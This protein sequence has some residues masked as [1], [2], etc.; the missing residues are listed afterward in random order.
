[1]TALPTPEQWVLKKLTVEQ[2]AEEIER[3]IDFVDRDG[4][5]VQLPTKFVRHF[6]NRDDGALPTIVAVS[7]LPLVF[8]D[9]GVWAEDRLDQLRG[10]DFRIQ[11]EV[12][13][14]VPKPGSVTADG[15]IEA[16]TFLTEKWLV[17]V[18]TDY[19]GK[20]TI[21]AAALT[22]IER[23]LL[24]QRP[25]FFVTAGRRG[26]GK[27]T[28]LV[29]L[30]K[31]VTGIWPAAAAWST[32]EE[33]RRKALLSYFLHGVAYILWDNIA[34]G[35]QITCPH[36]EKSCTAAYY[37]DRKLGVSQIVATAASTIHFFTGNNI[38]PRGDLASRSLEVRLELDRYDPE[39][40]DFKHPDPIGWTDNMRAEILGAFYTILLGNPT[41]KKPRNAPMRTRFKIWW[42][43]VGSALEHAAMLANPDREVDFR[44]MFLSREDEDEDSTSLAEVL[45]ILSRRWP[46]TF[47]ANDIALLVNDQSDPQGRAVRE[48]LYPGAP[49]NHM[50]TPKSVAGRLKSHC[51]EPVKAGDHTLILRKHEDAHS[52]KL[53]YFIHVGAA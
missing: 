37:S 35:S 30:I 11:P 29:M 36:I 31:A 14:C 2:M 10:I 9:G 6:M 7:T 50:A 49:P 17:D 13:A 24:D 43:L 51:D 4:R 16:M 44:K 15:V 25:A 26:G 22:I 23:C 40:R 41:L 1:M 42:R 33:E 48:F 18:A 27:T 5:S 8:A 53:V 28:T 12:S 19:A 32:N 45:E 46:T 3:H 47:S 52:K 34:R 39:N 21:I 38:G 20:C